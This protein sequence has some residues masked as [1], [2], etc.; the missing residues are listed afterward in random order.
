VLLS[1]LS[2][3]SLP[4]LTGQPSNPCVIDVSESLPHLKIRWLLDRPVKPGDD[5]E[6]ENAVPK[7]QTSLMQRPRRVVDEA[8]VEPADQRGAAGL[9]TAQRPR[10]LIRRRGVGAV[11]HDP[12]EQ[13]GD[14]AE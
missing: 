8:N 12:A 5:N 1:N 6:W 4:G 13:R 3:L 7:G 14:A 11:D 2:A 9:G 10:E